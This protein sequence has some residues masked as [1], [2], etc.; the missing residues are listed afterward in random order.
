LDAVLAA[1]KLPSEVTGLFNFLRFSEKT[2]Y[3]TYLR[4]I[5]NGKAV[6]DTFIVAGKRNGDS[7]LIF[8]MKSHSTAR[9]LPVCINYCI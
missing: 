2:E 8:Y 7:I 4:S 9:L 1:W 3:E 5:E 6:L